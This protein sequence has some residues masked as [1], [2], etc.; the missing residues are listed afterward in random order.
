MYKEPDWSA[1]PLGE[2]FKHADSFTEQAYSNALS[3]Y[4]FLQRALEACPEGTGFDA[5]IVEL[6]EQAQRTYKT[7]AKLHSK[8]GD[9]A[10]E[11]LYT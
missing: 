1:L 2:L 3:A 5:E 6:I 10:D 11:F 4:D 9:L 8:L 7:L